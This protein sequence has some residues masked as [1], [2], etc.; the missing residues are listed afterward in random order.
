MASY[1]KSMTAG[2]LLGGVTVAGAA[3]FIIN[4]NIQTSSSSMS[5]T[6]T[7][8]TGTA[9]AAKAAFNKVGPAF[10]RL[11]LHSS[12]DLSPTTKRL[13]FELPSPDL[14]SGLGLCSSV[15]TAAWPKGSFLPVIRPYTPVSR[16]D[17]RG[18]LELT[19]RRYPNGKMSSHIHSLVPGDTLLFPAVIPAYSWVP[20]KHEEITLIAGGAGITPMFQ[21]AQGILNDPS[22]KTK[23]NLVYG[24]R[25]DSEILFKDTFATWQQQF[26]D[27]FRATFVVREPNVGSS[28][29][30]ADIDA[31]LL[32]K[33]AP[34]SSSL[35]PQASK[36]FVCG[37]PGMET[38][39][40]GASGFGSA[41]GDGILA[42]LGYTKAQVFKF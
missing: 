23:I 4:R 25:N 26:P 5:L 27:R 9:P 32:S 28:Y 17:E 22:D 11:K 38:A 16:L 24:V 39:L 41:S 30:R 29:Q 21:L 36:V 14:V 3:V 7:T 37:P 18:F 8:T 33:V 42:Q 40:M 10:L 12:E 19:V 20:N 35:D 1:F 15:L 2:R 31:A 34:R 13:K 6:Q